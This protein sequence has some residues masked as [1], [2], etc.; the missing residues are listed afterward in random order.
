MEAVGSRAVRRTAGT[1]YLEEVG[2]WAERSCL[3]ILSGPVLVS[4][5]VS[6]QAALTGIRAGWLR[7][8]RSFSLI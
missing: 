8:N 7:N 1:S 6:V 5:T 2:C 4:R 3:E